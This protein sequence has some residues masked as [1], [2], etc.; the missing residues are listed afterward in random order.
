MIIMIG[1]VI[2]DSNLD[3]VASCQELFSGGNSVLEKGGRNGRGR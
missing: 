1:V 3:T 2:S